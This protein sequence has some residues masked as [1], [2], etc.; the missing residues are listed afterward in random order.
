MNNKF[1]LTKNLSAPSSDRIPTE[2]GVT[3][4]ADRLLKIMIEYPLAR[5]TYDQIREYK[6]DKTTFDSAL[7]NLADMGMIRWLEEE[8]V[9]LTEKGM[10][11]VKTGTY[12]VRGDVKG[13]EK[14]RR[15]RKK[16]H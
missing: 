6:F 9:E 15:K 3:R 5:M 16:D 11:E 12:R 2:P 8:M 1:H 13:R 7:N 14:Y 10:R 4:A